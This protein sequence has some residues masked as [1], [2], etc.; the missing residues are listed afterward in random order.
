[1]S[2]DADGYRGPVTLR[3]ADRE[4]VADAE[5]RGGTEPISGR[6][7]WYGRLAAS[8]AVTDLAAR[9]AR[10]IALSTPYGTVTTTLSDVD[11]WGR[12]RVAGTGCPPF[13]VPVEPEA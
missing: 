7:Q 3:A 1:M 9:Q 6:Y 4:V 8:P 5:L 12:Y 11:P 10:G 2:T 13:P